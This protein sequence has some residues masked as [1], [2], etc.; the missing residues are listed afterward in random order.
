[1]QPHDTPEEATLDP[2]S[3]EVLLLT[4]EHRARHALRTPLVLLYAV[5]GGAL[6]IGYLVSWV[7]TRDQM[8]FERPS[9][10][11]M[12][13]FGVGMMVAGVV[14]AVS[15]GRATRGLSGATQRAGK[16]YGLAY[17]LS[18]GGWLAVLLTLDVSQ[19]GNDTM[20]RLSGAVPLVL[21]ATIYA[22]GAAMVG[23]SMF[24]V[25]VLLVAAVAASSFVAFPT[26]YLL[27]VVGVAVAFGA[28]VVLAHRDEE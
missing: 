24:V 17:P 6:L 16:F 2:R 18:L 10:W 13:V 4:T 3:A 11:T 28:G 14:T 25:A 20:A 21:V 12:I 15:V 23:R 9:S 26:A 27:L 1:M 22:V 5:W 19:V 8:P 7:S